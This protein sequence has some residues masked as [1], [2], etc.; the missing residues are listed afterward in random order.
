MEKLSFL[1][2]TRLCELNVQKKYVSECLNYIKN[3]DCLY[4]TGIVMPYDRT[5]SLYQLRLKIAKDSDKAD[6]NYILD[7]EGIVQNME[8]VRS[9]SVGITTLFANEFSY[10]IFYEPK[11][12]L[13]LGILRG[14]GYKSI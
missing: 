12:L 10:C 1:D 14:G 13:I 11:G 4:R 5:L 7:F 3:E 6:P 8:Q 2:F 9:E